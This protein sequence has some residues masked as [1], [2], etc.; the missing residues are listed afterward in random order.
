MVARNKE[1]IVTIFLVAILS[2]LLIFLILTNLNFLKIEDL[3]LSRDLSPIQ[4]ITIVTLLSLAD[5]VNPCVISLLTVMIATLASMSVSRKDIIIRAIVF[6][7]VVFVTY[8]SLGLLIYF[9]YSFFYSISVASN[10]FHYLK[11]FLVSVLLIAGFINIRDAILGK[12]SIFSVPEFT[13]G[14]IKKLLT[15]TSLLATILLAA[16]VTLVELPCTGLFYL[17]LISFLHSV[18]QN[19]FSTLLILFYYNV[20]FILPEILIILLLVRGLEPKVIREKIYKKHR[21][22]MRFLVGLSLI[23]LA[24]VIWFFLRVG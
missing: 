14:A 9:G 23:G 8:F 16:T 22:L 4:F 10:V 17:G 12:K 15:Y 11:I 24:A 6:T 19:F 13:K 20:L 18:Q 21:R 7:L 5:S 1:K 2:A 3:E